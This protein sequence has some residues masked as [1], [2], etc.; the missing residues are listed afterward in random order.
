MR[1]TAYCMT[2]YPTFWALAAHGLYAAGLIPCTFALS[3]F[4]CALSLVQLCVFRVKYSL[5]EDVLYHWV[6]LGALLSLGRTEVV[7]W[8]NALVMLCY[9]AYMRFDVGHMRLMFMQSERHMEEAR[10]PS[11]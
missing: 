2:H 5:A 3:V 4:I 7:L 11:A 8:S 9:A 10:C 1:D 6:P